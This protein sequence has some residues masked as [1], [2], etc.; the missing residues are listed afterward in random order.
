MIKFATSIEMP[1]KGRKA[2]LYFPF[3]EG[4]DGVFL[5]RDFATFIQL[6]GKLKYVAAED[7]SHDRRVFFR[8]Q[9]DWYGKRFSP[10]AYRQSTKVAKQGVIDK[11]V[12]ALV[13][14]VRAKVLD[15][16]KLKGPVVEGVLQQ[17]GLKSRWIDAVDNIWIA[18][19]F[20]CHRCWSS[21]HGDLYYERRDARK[22]KCK[23]PYAYILAL[24]VDLNGATSKGNKGYCR[25]KLHEF[26]DLRRALPSYYIRPHVQHGVLLREISGY[27]NPRM[28]QSGL[29]QCVIKIP[30]DIALSWLGDGVSFAVGSI[31][32]PPHFD[33]GL[34]LLLNAEKAA[35]SCALNYDKTP[36][37]YSRVWA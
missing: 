27:G 33:T 1:K 5:V 31:F 16:G 2:P 6:I 34:Q 21:E 22:E 12:D 23:D 25:G 10:S 7:Y 9:P 26:L 3:A 8:G 13:D 17:Y 19:W 4:K 20:A 14:K 32:P 15:M 35:F 29:I 24:E 30:L 28:D 11:S 18:L 37:H 36:V